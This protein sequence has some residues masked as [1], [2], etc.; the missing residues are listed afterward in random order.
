[1]CVCV[2]VKEKCMWCVCEM[3]VD[4][5]VKNSAQEKS[6]VFRRMKNVCSFKL[7]VNEQEQEQIMREK[8]EKL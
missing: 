1:V 6:S 5:C 4:R 8:R 2:C 3:C 7:R